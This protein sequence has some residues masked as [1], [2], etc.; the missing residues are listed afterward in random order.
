[1]HQLLLL[2]L[3]TT[4]SSLA[5]AQ[6]RTL[7][8][9]KETPVRCEIQVGSQVLKFGM[10]KELALNTLSKTSFEL[11]EDREWSNEHKPDSRWYLSVP[12]HQPFAGAIRGGVKFRADKLDGIMVLWSPESDEQSDFAASLLNLLE[13]VSAEGSSSCT[14]RTTKTTHPQQEERGA[15]FEC[16]L[17]SVSISHTRFQTTFQGQRVPD[18]AEIYESLGNW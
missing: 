15:T 16:G 6:G 14:L 10:P 5:T 9:C 11:T 18:N 4:I 17:R 3:L 12:Q 1:M 7:F 2:F 8:N 13:R